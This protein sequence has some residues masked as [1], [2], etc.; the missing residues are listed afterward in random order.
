[1][2]RRFVTITEEIWSEGGSRLRHQREWSPSCRSS[3]TPLAGEEWADRPHGLVEGFNAP[4]GRLL[5]STVAAMLVAPGEA[6]GKGA[7]VGTD[8]EIEHGSAIIQ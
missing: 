8:G 2:L 3:L 7:L 4:L 6:L 1:M 5:G